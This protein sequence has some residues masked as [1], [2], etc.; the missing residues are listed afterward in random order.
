MPAVRPGRPKL[1]MQGP[2]IIRSRKLQKRL[3]AVVP[4]ILA[5]ALIGPAPGFYQA[6]PVGSCHGVFGNYFG[7]ILNPFGSLISSEAPLHSINGQYN[8]VGSCPYAG[9]PA[10]TFPPGPPS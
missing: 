3:L 8:A 4:L 9:M 5:V 7:T 2:P 1:Y 10:P 6:N